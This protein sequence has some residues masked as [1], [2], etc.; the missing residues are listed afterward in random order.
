VYPTYS[1]LV[2][3][4]IQQLWQREAPVDCR[5]TM[6][7]ESVCQVARSWVDVGSFHKRL[8]VIFINFTASVRNILYTPSY[9][10]KI[11]RAMVAAWSDWGKTCNHKQYYRIWG[12][13][14][15]QG[16]SNTE[17]GV[18][19]TMKFGWNAT[20]NINDDPQGF[21]PKWWPHIPRKYMGC[22]TETVTAIGLNFW[23]LRHLKS[24]PTTSGRQDLPPS[25]GEAERRKV[26]YCRGPIIMS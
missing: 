18:P 26:S 14:F 17:T 2:S 12:P 10:S 3:P 4:S 13:E 6:S 9:L 25:S 22:R 1:G 24:N 20:V 23:T 16:V 7:S 11:C 5:T 21:A 8:V 19:A 15:N